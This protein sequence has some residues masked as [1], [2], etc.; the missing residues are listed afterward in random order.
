V[1]RADLPHAT[2]VNLKLLAYPAWQA[3]INGKPVGLR[4]NPETGQIT[5]VLPAGASRTEVKFAQTWD[6]GVGTE[7]SIGSGVVLI[8]LW[9]L[10]VVVSRKRATEPREVV[11]V[12]AKAA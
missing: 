11:A 7:I 1:I 2:T 10:M 6:R 5:L 8:A 4:E 12:P 9:Q 3:S